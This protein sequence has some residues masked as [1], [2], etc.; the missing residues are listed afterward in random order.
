[1]EKEVFDKY[2]EIIYDK[3]G[4]ALSDKKVSLVSARIN[5]R[6]RVLGVPT[7]E[8]YLEKVLNDSTGE[9][10]VELLNVISTNVTNFYRES[11]HFFY[12][13]D[14]MKTWIAEGQCKFR[15]WSAASSSGEEPYTIAMMLDDAFGANALV[16]IK[17]LATDIST[18]VL[19]KGID[20]KYSEDKMKGI[21]L[22]FKKKYFIEKEENGVVFYTVIDRI[23]K[24]VLFRRIN[25][26]TPPFPM[27]GPMDMIFCRN[28]MIYFDKQLR[29]LLIGE[30]NKLIRSGGYLFLGSSESMTGY[31]QCDFVPKKPSVYFRR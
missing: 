27:K 24:Y 20:G 1:M 22:D 16:D 21:P 15:I 30:Y 9:E 29:Q 17:I 26:S 12:M 7:E 3:S 2:K 4:I 5:K 8:A 18:S 25:L 13:L 11:D 14:V 31:D 23:K 28:V 6:M 10:F 19:K